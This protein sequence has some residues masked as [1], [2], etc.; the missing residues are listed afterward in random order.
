MLILRNYKLIKQKKYEKR[1]KKKC[2]FVLS[3]RCPALGLNLSVN[4]Y[5]AS[6][7]KIIDAI[8]KPKN[9]ARV[10]CSHSKFFSMM[11]ELWENKELIVSDKNHFTHLA[12][13]I[14]N[15]FEVMQEKDSSE[16]LSLSSIKTELYKYAEKQRP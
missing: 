7:Q 16:S 8:T 12:T 1:F 2:N 14:Y 9:R 11:V 6:L 15:H 3:F 5:S 4:K 13:Y 10:T